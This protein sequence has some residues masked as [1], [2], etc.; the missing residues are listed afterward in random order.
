MSLHVEQVQDRAG[1]IAIVT[2]ANTGIGYEITLGLVRSGV[3]VIM[4]C[5]NA[6]KAQGAK[7]KILLE[8]PA[9]HIDCISVDISDLVSVENFSASFKKKY[10]QLDILVNNAGIMS[11]MGRKSKQGI[12]MQWATNFFGHFLLTALLFDV[13]PDTPNSRIVSMSSVAHK[14]ARIDFDDINCDHQKRGKAYG[15]SKLACLLFAEELNRRIQLAGKQI[16]AIPVHP[17]GSETSIFNEMSRIEYHILKAISPY[18]AHNNASAAQSALYA[19]LS[20]DAEGGRYYGPIGFLEFKGKVGHAK[21][22]R[23]A[24]KAGLSEIIWS[25]AEKMTDKRFRF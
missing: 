24:R 21:R 14:H 10:N 1:Q 13:M 5:R 11:Y 20:P 3:K 25:V 9:A 4:A 7:E 8:V 2:G 18:I 15:Q 12:E 23:Y 22:S 16:K 17:G 19:S 6:S